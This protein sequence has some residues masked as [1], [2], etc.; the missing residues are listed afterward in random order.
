MQKIKLLN[1]DT[2]KVHLKCLKVKK[3]ILY[4]VTF[5]LFSDYLLMFV[6]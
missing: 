4:F 5:L 6:L 2:I 3:I 1:M